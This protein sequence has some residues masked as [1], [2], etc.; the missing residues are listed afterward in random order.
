MLHAM[1][2]AFSDLIFM[3]DA[4]EKQLVFVSDN[5]TDI[6][7][8]HHNLFHTG[9]ENITNL[10]HPGDLL[11]VGAMVLTLLKKKQLMVKCNLRIRHAN[12]SYRWFSLRQVVFSEKSAE[13]VQ[14]IFG[15]LVDINE[16][17]QN[18][19]RIRE[20]NAAIKDYIF[21]ASHTIRAPLSNILGVTALFQ[22]LPEENVAEYRQWAAML[23]EQAL[24][25]DEIIRGMI[26]NIT[27]DSGTE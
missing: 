6:L 26:K 10:I 16:R 15:I 2:T 17:K 12:G 19:I 1:L 11:E 14:Y 18:E 21:A 22:D 4:V 5:L 7:G 20:Q 13:K 24:V 23:H 3:Y 25:L 8:Y 9:V 27:V